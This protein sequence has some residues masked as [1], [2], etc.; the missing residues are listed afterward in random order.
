MDKLAIYQ[1]EF[2]AHCG[3]TEEERTV[4]Q[5]L[6]LDI[7]ID[8]DLSQATRSDRLED[9]IDYDRLCATVL[10]VGRENHVNLIETLA[11]KIA[12]EILSDRRI[13]SVLVR[14][15]KLLPPREEIRAGF[16]VEIFRASKKK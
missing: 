6:S 5:R 9:T 8:C 14:L 12:A 16:L 3:P 10:K 4:G 11:E 2:Q 15:K 1:I 13:V 7:E